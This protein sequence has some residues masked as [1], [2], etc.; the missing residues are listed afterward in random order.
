MGSLQGDIEGLL[1]EFA[2]GNAHVVVVTTSYRE[3]ELRGR[4]E[5]TSRDDPRVIA[6]LAADDATRG[7]APEQT[8]MADRL[9]SDGGFP[10][11]AW[12]VVM[13]AVAFSLVG[14][15]MLPRRRR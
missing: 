1:R 2:A 14:A 9:S 10:A 4:V 5:A 3:G 7:P 11:W 8:M 12:A 6:A 15:S 13:G